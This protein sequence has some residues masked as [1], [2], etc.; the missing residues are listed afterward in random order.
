MKS[1]TN[2][3]IYKIQNIQNLKVYIGS[4]KNFKERFY[5]HIRNLDNKTHIN[6]FLQNSWDKYG[7]DNFIFVPLLECG[8]DELLGWEQYFLDMYQPEYN[9][10]KVA[11]NTLGY[12]HTEEYLDTRRKGFILISPEGQI[13]E[14]KGIAKTAREL[15]I[16]FR[17]LQGMLNGE[18]Y[19]VGGYTTSLENYLILKRFGNFQ[20]FNRSKNKVFKIRNLS[21]EEVVTVYSLKEVATKYNLK[22]PNLIGVRDGKYKQIKGWVLETND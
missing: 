21:T 18:R 4:A 19:S 15:N 20:T 11:G 1:L 14:C 22:V 6:S 3:G 10:C 12:K 17:H 5:R 9:I 2:S 13:L 7:K 16:N 8:E